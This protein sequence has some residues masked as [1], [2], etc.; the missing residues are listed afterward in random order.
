MFIGSGR[1]PDDRGAGDGENLTA[2]PTMGLN[3]WGEEGATAGNGV[4]PVKKIGWN[5]DEDSAAGG[6]GDPFE[7]SSDE[8]FTGDKSSG[9]TYK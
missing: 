9:M 2:V 1:N 8:F 4:E 5:D 7:E 6:D 3:F